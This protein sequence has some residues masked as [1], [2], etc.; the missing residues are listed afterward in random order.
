MD[1][2]KLAKLIDEIVKLRI[3]KI[4]KSEDFKALIK[5]EAHKEVIK[6]L[7]EAKGETRTNKKTI[8]TPLRTAVSVLGEDTRKKERIYPILPNRAQKTFSKNPTLNAILSATAGNAS[9]MASYN[10]QSS[11]ADLVDGGRPVKI[12]ANS[13]LLNNRIPVDVGNLANEALIMAQSELS[14]Y[15]MSSKSVTEEIN[16]DSPNYTNTNFKD[17]FS[18][19]YVEYNEDIS[20]ID[21]RM[22]LEGVDDGLVRVANALTRDYSQLLE[23]ADQKAKDLRQTL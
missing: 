16:M 15:G 7:L 20:N 10:N 3:Q 13:T 14:K 6:I 17:T 4:L 5:E 21:D 11:L 8:S 22:I 9:A 1:N 18:D 23:K 19:Q 2:K 12:G